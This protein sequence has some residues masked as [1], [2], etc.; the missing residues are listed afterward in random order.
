MR[1]VKGVAA[2]RHVCLTA[3]ACDVV[4]FCLFPCESPPMAGVEEACRPLQT[5]AAV[6]AFW[7][8]RD[9]RAGG[10][11]NSVIDSK[12]QWP[13]CCHPPSHGAAG[14]RS[15]TINSAGRKLRGAGAACGFGRE[16][17]RCCRRRRRLDLSDTK[18]V[19]RLPLPEPR[20]ASPRPFRARPDGVRW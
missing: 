5:S 16:N 17:V 13:K 7:G 15:M 12:R 4:V 11:Q 8:D 3:V 14:K 2:G 18:E 9:R 10:S 20:H 1:K 19:S 6:I